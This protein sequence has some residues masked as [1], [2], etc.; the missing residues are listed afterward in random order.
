[1][2]KVKVP[3]AFRRVVPPEEGSIPYG[4]YYWKIGEVVSGVEYPQ[5]LADLLRF[6][7]LVVKAF[8]EGKERVAVSIPAEAFVSSLRKRAKIVPELERRIRE[9]T[10]TEAEVYPQG[11]AALPL[12]FEQS[13]EL[14]REA[15]TLV[16]DGGFNTINVAVADG[17]MDIQY[18]FTY[19]NEL[20]IRDLLTTFAE[21]LREKL[22]MEIPA[23]L[24]KLK[25]AFLKGRVDVGF[26]S[27]EVNGEKSYAV[28]TFI[29][30]MWS[31][32]VGDLTRTGV[33][34]EQVV[35]VGGI[36]Y[37]VGSVLK[38]RVDKPLFVP[39]KD[40]EFYTVM[41]MHSLSGLPSI[42]F[43]FGDV[44]LYGF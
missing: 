8:A 2:E 31:R 18:V 5:I 1:M 4:G 34:F 7:P 27:V 35:V 38:E 44:K 41:G 24:Q 3:S 40:A 42:D 17:N 15:P 13:E 43:G 11:V 28:N 36:A 26:R 6:Y 14:S 23:N 30:K 10:G 32:L 25:G 9:E 21:L 33:E 39:E 37:Y 22:D 20:G 29:D 16:I 12:V 19:Y